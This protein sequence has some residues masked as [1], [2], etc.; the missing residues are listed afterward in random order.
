MKVCY[1]ISD[2]QPNHRTWYSDTKG[3]SAVLIKTE[4]GAI[5]IDAGLPDAAQTILSHMSQLGVLRHDPKWIILGHA[6]FD[7]TGFPA[8]IQLATGARV[9]TNA[10]SAAL[11]SR[12]EKEDIHFG[13]KYPYF[14][15]QTDRFLLDGETIN[16]GGIKLT[17]Y[18]TL[19]HTPGSVSWTWT[20]QRNGKPIR[21]APR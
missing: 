6:H 12:R 10:E 15:V 8:E 5:L 16:L 17:A 4:E 19:A 1:I 14:P 13:D 18:F 21:I 9:A 2:C 20:D 11:L 3:L 7:H